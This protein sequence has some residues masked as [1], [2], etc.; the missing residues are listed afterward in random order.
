MVWSPSSQFLIVS[1]RVGG[2]MLLIDSRDGQAAKTPLVRDVGYY[3]L[4]SP[5]EEFLVVYLTVGDFANQFI[6][7][8]QR[9]EQLIDDLYVSASQYDLLVAHHWLSDRQLLVEV[10]NEGYDNLTL[11]N[12]QT[13]ERQILQDNVGD[14]ALSPDEHM[15]AFQVLDIQDPSKS[16]KEIR[17][18]D[19]TWDDPAPL[20][21]LDLDAPARRFLWRVDRES[22]IVLFE[23]YSLQ[24]YDFE[25]EV[26]HFIAA[27]PDD[28]RWSMRRVVCEE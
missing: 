15:V 14:Y 6:V 17:F 20:K 11:I 2:E 23:D 21:N 8:N 27:I 25:T 19:L 7:L 28:Q 1:S 12:L 5:T 22:L 10:W 3:F 16:P 18:F 4:W 9:G 26:W 24:E 13:G